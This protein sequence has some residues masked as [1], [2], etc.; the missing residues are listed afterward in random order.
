MRATGWR[1]PILA[2]CTMVFGTFP[3]R[4]DEVL[5]LE[6]A[7]WVP[8]TSVLTVP[9]SY[10]LA[11]SAVVPTSYVIPTAYSTAYVI[12]SAYAAPVTTL[13][14]T[15]YETRFRRRGLFGRRLVETTRAYYIPTTAYYPTTYYYPTVFSTPAIMDR[16]VVPTEYVATTA[17]ACCGDVVADSATVVRSA[18]VV[19]RPAAAPARPAPAAPRSRPSRIESESDDESISSDVGPAQA[20]EPPPVR[21][22]PAAPRTN[23]PRGN[24]TSPPASPAAPREKSTVRPDGGGAGATPRTGGPTGTSGSANPAGAGAQPKSR[25]SIPAPTAPSGDLPEVTPA[26]DEQLFPAPEKDAASKSPGTVRR[27]NMR[28]VIPTTRSIRSEYRNVLVGI[29]RA[30]E[31]DE[32]E[33]GVRIS[34]SSRDNPDVEKVAMSNAFGKF[35]VRVPDGDWTVRVTMPSGRIYPVSQ[36]TV[37][38]GMV[39]DDSGRDIPSLIITR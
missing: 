11:T 14:P 4:G 36:I 16:A 35:A 18:P 5:F 17:T 6:T 10:L 33:D 9:T 34:V 19:D 1:W 30:R 32:P 20:A 37:S 7:D 15:Y 31:T 23:E 29:V 21:S 25:A 28:P 3:A 2:L 38:N 26:E 13:E 27:D 12:E 22:A 39:F 24:E 8:T